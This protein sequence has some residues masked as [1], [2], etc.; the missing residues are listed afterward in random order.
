MRA[1]WAGEAQTRKRDQDG[2]PDHV[3]EQHEQKP[4]NGR[5]P[6]AFGQP[7]TEARHREEDEK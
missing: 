5:S 7:C 1:A 6:P 4:A 3:Q 2:E